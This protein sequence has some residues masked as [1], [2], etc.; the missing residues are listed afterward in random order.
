MPRIIFFIAILFTFIVHSTAAPFPIQNKQLHVVAKKSSNYF[1][2]KN[3]YYLKGT[4]QKYHTALGKGQGILLKIELPNELLRKKY[5]IDSLFI[6]NKYYPISIIENDKKKFAEVNILYNNESIAA[7]QPEN[8]SENKS[9][10]MFTKLNFEKVKSH[11][12]VN[13]NGISYVLFI[14][15]YLAI[16]NLNKY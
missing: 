1:L 13:R 4:F 2:N 5:N 11:I 6:E 16:T 3:K 14:S 10:M 7:E 8:I 15:G 9:D 12:V